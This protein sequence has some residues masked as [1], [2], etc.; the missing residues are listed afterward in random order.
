MLRQ[1]L[2]RRPISHGTVTHAHLHLDGERLVMGDS[3]WP[4]EFAFYEAISFRVHCE[5]RPRSTPVVRLSAVPEAEPCGWLK[6]R[7]GVSWQIGP[8][9]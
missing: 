6:D 3:A 2:G 4:H 7:Y 8:R 9:R 1:G 5:A